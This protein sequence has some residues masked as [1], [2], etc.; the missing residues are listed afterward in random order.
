MLQTVTGQIELQEAGRILEHE[1][2]LVGFVEDGKLTPDMYDRD[3]VV[4]SILPQLLALKE[5]GCRTMV[6]CAPEYL[7]RDPY[8][9]RRLSE[10]SGVHLVTNTG[11]Y[12]RP[13]LPAFAYEMTDRELAGL[14]TKEAA[15][16]IGESS[17][18][19]GFIKI[20]LNDGTAIDD[21]QLTILRAAMRTSLESGLPIQ[22]HTIGADIARHAFD[23]MKEAQFD[24]ERFIWVHAQT[25][26]DDEVYL[27]I[28]EAGGWI[29][30]D[31][32]NMD[33]GREH[34]DRLIRLRR[35]GV[36][37]RVLLSQDT[38]WYNVGTP[39]GGTLNPYHRLFTEFFPAAEADG[40]DAQWL[41]EC[42]T[43]RAFTAMSRRA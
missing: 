26:D 17:V 19:P 39:G 22:C 36:G 11:F 14:W 3:E 12:K 2:V 33:N 9:L 20:A 7:G 30:I 16:G 4:S 6:D 41:E 37:D 15:E 21:I 10:L 8:V 38:G 27:R 35:L 5:A 1:H 31:N 24:Q 40:V 18:Y 42:V 23:V 43:S 32:I 29:S 34:V 28:A 13:Y 25:F